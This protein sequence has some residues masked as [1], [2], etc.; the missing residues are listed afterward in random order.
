MASVKSLPLDMIQ[1]LMKEDEPRSNQTGRIIWYDKEM[2][3]ASRGCSSP[4]YIRFDRVPTCMMHTIL[5]CN[6]LL[7]EAEDI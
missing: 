6:E 3:C 4:T 7:S 2:R 1:A 5:K